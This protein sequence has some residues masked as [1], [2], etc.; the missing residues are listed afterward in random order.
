MPQQYSKLCL[1][2]QYAKESREGQYMSTDTHSTPPHCRLLS[3]GQ[4]GDS[5]LRVH[6]IPEDF[7]FLD[8][9]Y[10][11]TPIELFMWQGLSR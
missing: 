7:E 6:H 3:E 2:G 5:D 8:H 9:K 10:D 1:P 11:D 4:T